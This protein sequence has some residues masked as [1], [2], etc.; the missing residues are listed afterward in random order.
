VTFSN[1][2]FAGIWWVM[3][4]IAVVMLRRFSGGVSRRLAAV[5]RTPTS[6]I[7]QAPRE[8][9]VE[10]I[11]RVVASE[12]G[13]VQAAASDRPAVYARTLVERV[14]GSSRD[15]VLDDLATRPFL[16]DDGSGAT[17]WVEIDESAHVAV[18]PSR[19]TGDEA[20]SARIGG[21]LVRNGIMDSP[22]KLVW[23]EWIIEA[24]ANV[25]VLGDA[26]SI[27]A[28]PS[29]TQYRDQPGERLRIT[30]P[31]KSTKREMIVSTY[32]EAGLVHRLQGQRIMFRVAVAV[33]ILVA[34]AVTF[35]I[36][37]R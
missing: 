30:A 17:A 8:G 23:R 31:P 36:A 2:L 35:F 5:E 33:V 15:T 18:D 12:R 21:L 14:N 9:T 1:A 10:I 24:D 25:Y 13:L 19:L 7:A 4:G 6:P 11:G 20:E 29:L 37:M 27:S 34:V 26:S 16:V 28:G 32:G 22:K 3:S